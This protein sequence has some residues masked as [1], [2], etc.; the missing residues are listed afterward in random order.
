MMGPVILSPSAADRYGTGAS[1]Y[2]FGIATHGETKPN[3]P[4]PQSLVGASVT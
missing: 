2:V 1:R 3:T 4:L